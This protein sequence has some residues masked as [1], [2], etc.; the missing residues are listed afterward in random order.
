M[1]LSL[2]APGAKE[3]LFTH[4]CPRGVTEEEA[5]Q[6]DTRDPPSPLHYISLDDALKNGKPTVVVSTARSQKAG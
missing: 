2:L 5:R 4:F 6:I 1:R 3:P